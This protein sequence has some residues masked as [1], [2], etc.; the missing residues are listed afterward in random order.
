MLI[1][2][3]SSIPPRFPTIGETL[4]C[5]LNQS[6]Q[7]DRVL[8][9]I[10][11]TYRRF[12]DWDGSLPQ[13][14]D[15]VEIVRVPQDYGP[16]TKILPAARA[17][18]GHDVDILFCDDDRIYPTDWAGVFV[19]ARKIHPDACIATVAREASELF[20]S[21][22]IRDHHPRAVQR[23][24]ITDIPFILRY[25][26]FKVKNRLF[27]GAEKPSRK[28]VKKAGYHDLFM[29]LGGVMVHPDHFDDTAFEI[30]DTHWMVD[31]IWLSGMLARRGIPIWTPANIAQPNLA[32]AHFVSGLVDS[33][34]KGL[35]RDAADRKCYDYLRGTYDIW[36]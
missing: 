8:L 15:G 16:A 11:E 26:A 21:K 22:Q 10:P 24:W 30:P 33:Q 7:A 2:S 31:D 28:V 34:I 36:R 6:V 23:P 18:R 9:H 19:K 3:L 29:G 5:L 27:G 25:A 17:F 4:N 32:K 1:I 14:P 12:P 20:S 35:D 13:V